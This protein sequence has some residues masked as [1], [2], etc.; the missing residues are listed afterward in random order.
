MK[1]LGV[2]KELSEFHKFYN[3]A[4]QNRA[5]ESVDEAEQGSTVSLI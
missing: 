1:K 4:N 3:S 5:I 2:D